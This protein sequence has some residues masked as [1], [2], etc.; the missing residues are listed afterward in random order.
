MGR[1]LS[2]KAIRLCGMLGNGIGSKGERKEGRVELFNKST[3]SGGVILADTADG[4]YDAVRKA[5]EN[6][7][8]SWAMASANLVDECARN[9][10]AKSH[11]SM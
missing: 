9:K 3:L 8:N 5:T 4:F 2:C 11:G 10:E 1:L 7:L 6:S